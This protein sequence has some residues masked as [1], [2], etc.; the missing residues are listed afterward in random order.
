MSSPTVIETTTSMHTIPTDARIEILRPMS[1]YDIRH[2]GKNEWIS[3]SEQQNG[4]LVSPK[5]RLSN[6]ERISSRY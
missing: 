5:K 4:V 6:D 2:F 3:D 1:D